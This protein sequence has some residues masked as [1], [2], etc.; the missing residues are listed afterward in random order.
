MN[1][2]G[3]NRLT[4]QDSRLSVALATLFAFLVLL[5][6]MTLACTSSDSTDTRV[7]PIDA[8]L[9]SPIEITDVSSE[10]ALVRV[11]TSIDVVCSVV[12]GT[13]TNYGSQSTDLDMAGRGHSTHAPALRNLEPDT[14]YHYRLQ[15][16]GP[17]GTLYV[18]DDMTFRTSAAQ[19]S[20]PGNRTNLASLTVGARVVEASSQFGDS[21][22]WR[23]ENAIDGDPDTEWS[24]AGDGDAAYIVI[25]LAKPE[26]IETIALWTRTMGSSAQITS[27]KVITEDGIE[28]GPFDVP[29]GLQIYEF[30]VSASAQRLRFEVVSSSGGN[31]GLIE[32]AVFAKE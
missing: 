3:D 15:G 12:F 26:Q 18:S 10:G 1:I 11:N 27:F 30:A 19:A 9:A 25:E 8:I 4:G 24:S 32:I 16:S 2:D 22:A 23:P 20:Q 29:D 21:A 28:L 13:S 6:V 7:Q 31:T 17:D 5:A 14:L